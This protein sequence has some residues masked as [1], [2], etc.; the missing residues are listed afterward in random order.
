MVTG[1]GRERIFIHMSSFQSLFAQDP[2]FLFNSPTVLLY[3]SVET[4]RAQL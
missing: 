4:A 2:K 3:L 1:S